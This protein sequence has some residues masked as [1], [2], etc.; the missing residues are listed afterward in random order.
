MFY[1]QYPTY[2]HHFSGKKPIKNEHLIENLHNL[3]NLYFS[4]GSPSFFVLV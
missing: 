2:V 1:L 3:Y 4:L